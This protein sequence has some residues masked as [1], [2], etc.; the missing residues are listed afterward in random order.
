MCCLSGS[1][2][3]FLLLSR[4]CCPTKH[5]NAHPHTYRFSDRASHRSIRRGQMAQSL[6]HNNQQRG[7][8][9]HGNNNR[10]N[11]NNNSSGGGNKKMPSSELPLPQ[12]STLRSRRRL[13]NLLVFA[14][15][16][17]MCCWSPHMVCF[18][19]A[20][21]G[22]SGGDGGGGSGSADGDGRS[23]SMCS[24][25]VSEFTLLLGMYAPG[26]DVRKGKKARRAD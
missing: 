23:A 18:L 22:G 24:P 26:G 5:T 1:I 15:G 13:A 6:R 8:H 10:R 12:T 21:W 25:I 20:E 14:A 19:G 4:T 3:F 2:F 7:G 16:I 9:R 11:H 17:F